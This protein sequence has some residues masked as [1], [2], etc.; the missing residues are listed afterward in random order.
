MK[1]IIIK[2]N[3]QVYISTRRGAWVWNRLDYRGLPSDQQWITNVFYHFKRWFGMPVE[4]TWMESVVGIIFRFIRKLLKTPAD[5][6]VVPGG[7][8]RATSRTGG[9]PPND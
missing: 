1:M 6:S 4:N 8:E 2:N 5:P 7:F 3:L 9:A